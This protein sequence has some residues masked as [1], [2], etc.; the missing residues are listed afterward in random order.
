LKIVIFETISLTWSWPWP[1]M[2]LKVISSWMSHQ[3]YQIPLFGL[4]LHCISLWMYIRTDG[5]MD[6]LT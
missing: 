1:R 4:W 2:T 6:I 5:Q 3:P